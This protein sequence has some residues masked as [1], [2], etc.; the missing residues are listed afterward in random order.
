[1][2]FTMWS[3]KSRIAACSLMMSHWPRPVNLR[4]YLNRDKKIFFLPFL[5]VA[6]IY[7][8]IF[9]IIMVL[10]IKHLFDRSL[11]WKIIACRSIYPAISI[12]LTA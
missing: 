1:M 5:R 10:S 12:T 3:A 11:Y 8:F 7:V 9:Q 4:E 2:P 6:S